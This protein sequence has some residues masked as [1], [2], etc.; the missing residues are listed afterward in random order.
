M[1]PTKK[2]LTMPKKMY[3][4]CACAAGYNTGNGWICRC[5]PVFFMSKNENKYCVFTPLSGVDYDDGTKANRT[6]QALYQ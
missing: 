4:P 2:L 3:I 1:M 6:L 5:F